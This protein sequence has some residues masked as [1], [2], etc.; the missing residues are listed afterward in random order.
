[1]LSDGPYLYT[2]DVLISWQPIKLENDTSVY[3]EFGYSYVSGGPYTFDKANH[4]Y[5]S[6]TIMSGLDASKPIYIVA[7][8][9]SLPDGAVN[10]NIVTSVL[11]DEVQPTQSTAKVVTNKLGR[12]GDRILMQGNN[13]MIVTA[14]FDDCFYAEKHDKSWGIRVASNDVNV[15]SVVEVSGILNTDCNGERYVQPDGVNS[16]YGKAF[17]PVFIINRCLGGSDWNYESST[18]AGQIGV[19]GG[20]GLNNIGL[21]VTTTG[22]CTYVNDHT[23]TLNDGSGV[24]V[25]CETPSGMYAD[26]SWRYVVVT[27]ISSIE[28]IDDTYVRV[29][30]VTSADVVL[31]D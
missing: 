31:V 6:F 12:D 25:T 22:A 23:F 26:S 19:T 3:Y 28:K 20:T 10:K 8:A 18:G 4:A 14:Q 7:R 9:V 5:G 1:M 15:G 13:A 30:K 2:P 17:M 29:I 24:N 11:S 27:G 16:L 21:L